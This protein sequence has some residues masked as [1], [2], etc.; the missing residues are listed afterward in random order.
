MDNLTLFGGVVGVRMLSNHN[1]HK[2]WNLTGCYTIESR[3]EVL[4]LSL[5]LVVIMDVSL[6]ST[7]C[8]G[9]LRGL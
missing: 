5:Q 8:I 3:G 4:L 7:A 9:L 2:S 6:S 1:I